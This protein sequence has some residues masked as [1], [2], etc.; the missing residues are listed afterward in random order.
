MGGGRKKKEPHHEASFLTSLYWDW[1]L[2]SRYNMLAVRLSRAAVLSAGSRLY[3][4][5]SSFPP[6]P[7]TPGETP[8]GKKKI[9]RGHSAPKLLRQTVCDW[10]LHNLRFLIYTSLWAKRGWG[11]IFSA[12]SLPVKMLHTWPPPPQRREASPSSLS[13][14]G[15][16][17]TNL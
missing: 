8:G 6:V 9:P 2:F 7:P 17:I 1:V 3:W 4:L 13:G 15:I 11:R 16:L 12:V 5:I 10:L 14:L